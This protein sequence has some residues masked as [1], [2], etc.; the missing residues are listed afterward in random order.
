[1]TQCKF[2]YSQIESSRTKVSV[3]RLVSFINNQPIPQLYQDHLNRLDFRR[4]PDNLIYN[5]Q[6]HL[7][8]A[9]FKISVPSADS[10]RLT[11]NYVMFP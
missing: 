9:D 4:M 7:R 8:N 6:L 3:M 1:M 5:I 2:I 10:Q 11:K